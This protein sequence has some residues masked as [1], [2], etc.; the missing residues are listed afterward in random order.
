MSVIN[1]H[2]VG[3][4]HSAVAVSCKYLHCRLYATLSVVKFTLSLVRKTVSVVRTTLSVANIYSVGCTHYIVSYSVRC[5]HLLCR[6]Y[7]LLCRL[8]TLTLSV[9]CITL[10]IAKIYSVGCMHYSVGYKHSLCRLYALLSCVLCF[11]T[12]GL[13]AFLSFQFAVT[14]VYI[15]I[16][17]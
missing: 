4:T 12:N 6:L 9:V 13:Y 16:K 1:L 17:W 15:S 8:C 11:E 14:S 3:C 5:K 7:A 10:S 2:S